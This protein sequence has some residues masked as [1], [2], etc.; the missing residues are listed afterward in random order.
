MGARDLARDRLLTQG[1]SAPAFRSPQEVVGLLGAVQAQD[2]RGS[3]WAIGLRMRGGTAAE[4][5]RAA[6]ERRIV[7]TWPMRGTL[8]FVPALDVRWMLALLTPRIVRRSAGRLRSLEL[9][10]AVFARG[11]KVLAK[12]L[13]GGGVLTRE[14]MYETLE[15]ARISTRGQRGIHILWR[16]AQ[17]GLICFGPRAGRQHTFVLLEEWITRGRAL[18]GVEAVAELARRFFIGHG[19]AAVADFAWWAG[20]TG[21]E[22]RAGVEEASSGLLRDAANGRTYWLSPDAAS[23]HPRSAGAFLLPAFDE[24]LVGYKDRG[25]AIDAAHAKRLA[26]LLSP[27]IVAGGRI[28][29]TWRRTRKGGKA[30]IELQPFAPLGMTAVRALGAVADRYGAFFETPTEVV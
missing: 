13:Q 1:I 7:R 26:S 28:V 5:E 17:D 29:G 14:R 3:L 24:F 2:Y 18:R 25:A 4:V 11:A 15:S 19:P 16:L 9:D 8:H 23:A 12:A 6:A 20:L 22:A 21:A 10:D 27:T 30:A